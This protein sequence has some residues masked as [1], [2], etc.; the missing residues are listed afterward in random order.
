[1]PRL[2]QDRE[3]ATVHDVHA[4]FA[5]AFDERAEVRVQLGCAARQVELRHGSR[6]EEG[7]HV[8][9]RFAA[10]HLDPARPGVHVAVQAAL[11]A[12][13]AEVDLERVEPAARDRREIG[14]GHARQRCVHRGTTP[15]L[16]CGQ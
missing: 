16:Q 7:E 15:R 9:D 10:H 14:N 12:L 4:K 11:V 2:A 8:V 1:M 13:V 3:V 6:F 5:R